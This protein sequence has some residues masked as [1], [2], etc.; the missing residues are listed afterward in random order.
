MA[1]IHL[2]ILLPLIAAIAIGVIYRY[3]KRLHLGWFVLPVPLIIV[4]YH[5][6]TP[7]R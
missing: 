7:C 2:A 6:R 1:L 4:I 3:Y 5:A